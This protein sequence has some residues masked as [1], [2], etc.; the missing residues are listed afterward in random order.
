MSRKRPELCIKTANHSSDQERSWRSR[1]LTGLYFL[2]FMTYPAFICRLKNIRE[3]H[4]ISRAMS[5]LTRISF[6]PAIFFFFF[7]AIRIPPQSHIMQ[8]IP[9]YLQI[10]SNWQENHHFYQIEDIIPGC[11]IESTNNSIA[12]TVLFHSY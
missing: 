8:L 12:G 7:F 2:L 9:H 1:C 5:N 4:L 10:I 6:R 3:R 11:C